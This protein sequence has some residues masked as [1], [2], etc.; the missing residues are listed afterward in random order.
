MDDDPYFYPGT[1]VLRNKENIHDP[2]ELAE[3]E[4]RA[5][6][7]RA[8]TLPRDLPITAD[9][10]REIHRYIF[11]EVYDWA[12]QDRTTDLYK[13][14]S[15]FSRAEVVGPQME[16]RFAAINA[17]DNL[18]GLTADQFAAR[19]AEHICELNVIHPF[20]D[21]NGRT[22]RSFLDVL[23]EQAGHE[24][25]M[26]RIDQSAWEVASIESFFTQ[27]YRPMRNVIAGA[28]VEREDEH[29]VEPEHEQSSSEPALDT[30][31]TAENDAKDLELRATAGELS[32]DQQ[33]KLGRTLNELK[34]DAA[35]A[36]GSTPDQSQG[37]G[38]PQGGGRS[39]GR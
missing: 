38:R 19:A 13:G 14:G 28:L 26:T 36:P 20:R 25:D 7:R 15:H 3:F 32:D 35:A 22:M 27:D 8:E 18:R 29:Q 34:P 21:G 33:A 30:P 37:K 24:I 39:R 31:T 6:G 2:D 9:G 5:A 16:K 12:G 4:R 17:E 10:Y 23:A 11:Q 1:Y